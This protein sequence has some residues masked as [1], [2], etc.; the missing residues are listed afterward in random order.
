MWNDA[1][2]IGFPYAYRERILRSNLKLAK[3]F[4]ILTGLLG[5]SGCEFFYLH[6][7]DCGYYDAPRFDRITLRQP[8]LNQVYSEQVRVILDNDRHIDGYEIRY[9]FSG[10][11]PPGISHYQNDRNVFFDGTAI[12]LGSYSFTIAVEARYF[13]SDR[14]YYHFSDYCTYR[15][16]RNY[17]LTVEPF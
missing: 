11:L 17:L 8:I 1:N 4:L 2:R 3:V 15:S 12:A 7:T 9:D 10:R 6:Y 16:S 5:I 14:F 13:I